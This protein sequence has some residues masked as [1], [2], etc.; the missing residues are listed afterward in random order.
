MVR[1]PSLEADQNVELADVEEMDQ[2]LELVLG[3]LRAQHE[4]LESE[5]VQEELNSVSL[6]DIV[7]VDDCLALENSKLQE[8]EKDDEFLQVRLALNIEMLKSL[9]YIND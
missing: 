3:E 7:G 5:S 6:N 1:V 9:N 8:S 4:A 2:A